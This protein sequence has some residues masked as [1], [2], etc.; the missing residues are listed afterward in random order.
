MDFDVKHESMLTD[1]VRGYPRL[2][3]DAQEIL[4]FICELS[5]MRDLRR[6]V[7]TE[8][9]R[10]RDDQ[11]EVYF[12]TYRQDLPAQF[13]DDY[14]RNLARRRFSWHCIGLPHREFCAF[15][16]RDSI[17]TQAERESL[18]V[19][20]RARFPK[21]EILDHKVVGGARHLHFGAPLPQRPNDWI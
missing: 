18:I 8:F 11:E 19:D 12:Q 13:S 3:R 10:T 9:G 14:V 16:L 6:P 17:Y 21:A 7:V 15:D 1:P 5:K 20:V 4:A 2:S